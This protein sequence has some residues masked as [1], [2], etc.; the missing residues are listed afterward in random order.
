MVASGAFSTIVVVT[1]LACA[2][3]TS[4]SLDAREQ[5]AFPTFLAQATPAAPGPTDTTTPPSA[6]PPKRLPHAA[7][8]KNDQTTDQNK[9]YRIL[10]DR[11]EER[12][13]PPDGA[14]DPNSPGGAQ[15][16]E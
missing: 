8:P 15:N 13:R 1:V 6:N 3:G 5:S 12:P 10:T 14:I 7:L 11:S 2:S 9:R 16:R 4:Q